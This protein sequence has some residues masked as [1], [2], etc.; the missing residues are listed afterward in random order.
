MDEFAAGAID[1][2]EIDHLFVALAVAALVI[3]TVINA[4]MA[5]VNLT[6]ADVCAPT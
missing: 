3:T 6:R 4:Q 2:Y 5:A 1:W